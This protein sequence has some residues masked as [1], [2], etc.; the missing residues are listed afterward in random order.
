MN[1]PI[2]FYLNPDI[3]M[4]K[5][6]DSMQIDSGTTIAILKTKNH[7][8]SLEVRGEVKVFFNPDKSGEPTDGDYY[9]SPSEFPQELKDL[10]AE[11]TEIYR[12]DGDTKG[13]EHTWSLDDRVYIS[14]NNWFEIFKGKNATD[15]VPNAD[16]VDA[17]GLTPGEILSLMLEWDREE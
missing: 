13:I 17:E 8:I 9:T 14:E 4:T 7:F 10:I 16:V 15:P 6:K 3:D 2:T 5:I 12:K 1:N 11:N